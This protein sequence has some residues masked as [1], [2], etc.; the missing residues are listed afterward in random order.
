MP[1]LNE[2]FIWSGPNGIGA[3]VTSKKD[4]VPITTV[5]DAFKTDTGE[6][7]KVELSAGMLLY[8]FAGGATW[9]WQQ[10]NP[11]PA[12]FVI[13]P[14]WSPVVP[15]KEDGGLHERMKL[16]SLN[17]VSFR[18]WGRLTSVVKEDWSD[19][20]WVLQIELKKP[21]YAWFGRFKSMNRVDDPANSKRNAAVEKAG[22]KGG[23][24]PGG[25][26]QFYIPNMTYGDYV[27]SETW[28]NI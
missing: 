20:S 16:A 21:V 18:E 9:R 5:A 22:R 27:K 6:P 11:P 19:L 25:G 1:V 12:D 3:I 8:K 7:T 4:A 26:R 10:P 24:L 15:Y 28:K 14:W 17:G 13:S 2:G 23:N